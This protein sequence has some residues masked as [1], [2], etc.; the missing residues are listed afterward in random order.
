MIFENI[1]NKRNEKKLLYEKLNLE[2][3]NLELK[4]YNISK[5]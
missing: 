3:K 5:M 4:N 1:R 2:L